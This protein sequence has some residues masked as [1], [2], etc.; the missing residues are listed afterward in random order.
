MQLVFEVS[1]IASLIGVIISYITFRKTVK[2]K[3]ITKERKE[4]RE[5]IRNITEKIENCSYEDRRKVLVLLKTRINAY[6]IEEDNELSDSHIWDTICELEQCTREDYPQLKEKLIVFLSLLLK[7]D[8]ERSKKEVS[9]EPRLAIAYLMVFLAIGFGIYGLYKISGKNLERALPDISLILFLLIFTVM[10]IRMVKNSG[11]ELWIDILLIVMSVVGAF[12]IKIQVDLQDGGYLIVAVILVFLASCMWLMEEVKMYFEKKMYKKLVTGIWKKNMILGENGTAF[13]NN[14]HSI[15][16][17]G[18]EYYQFD[19]NYEILMYKYVCHKHLNRIECKNIKV[20]NK[21]ET[22][23]QWKAYVCGKYNVFSDDKLN[24]FDH[25]LNQR[26]RNVGAEFEYWKLIIPVI[27]TLLTDKLFESLY[28]IVGIGVDSI[29]QLI[30]EM[31]VIIVMILLGGLV[32]TKIIDPIARV[33]TERNFFIDYKEIIDEMLE[34][35]RK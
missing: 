34:K 17:I 1:A 5:S 7:Y 32:V 35:R 19:K 10:M 29:L 27:L 23:S 2:L 9:G 15:G 4:W 20:E 21:Y 8:W 13:M 33:S 22:Y 25:F 18:N 14:K 11:K 31:V 28:S 24:E 12:E 3:Y 26:I 16:H 6:G 30:I